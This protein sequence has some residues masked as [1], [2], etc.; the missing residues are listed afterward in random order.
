MPDVTQ[1]KSNLHLLIVPV[2]WLEKS[3]EFYIYVSG[4]FE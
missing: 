2:E 4:I 1:L 3:I